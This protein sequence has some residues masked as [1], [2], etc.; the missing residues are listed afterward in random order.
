MRPQD[1]DSTDPPL[2]DRLLG[3]YS[4]GEERGLS[5]VVSVLLLIAVVVVVVGAI[6]SFMFG[7]QGTA[8]SSGAPQATM[9][10]SWDAN[11]DDLTVTHDGG[12]ELTDQNSLAVQIWVEGQQER[13]WANASGGGE[14]P[15][16]IQA[17]DDI[18]LS[19]TTVDPGDTVRIVWV[20]TDG[21]QTDTLAK[22]TI[23]T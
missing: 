3:E 23:P 1:S 17:G 22:F 8:L 9:S 15:F 4:Q 20:G 18:T 2:R 14:Q 5:P 6:G 13:T 7:L 10:F 12:P 11:A 19:G 21:K 16:P